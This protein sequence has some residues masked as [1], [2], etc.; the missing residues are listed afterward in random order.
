[1]NLQQ[2]QLHDAD[3]LGVHLDPVA[4]VAE[5]SLAYYPSEEATERVL[6]TLRFKD[7]SHFN[8]IV[9]LA[10]LKSHSG[11]GNV[12]YWVTGETPGVSYI[13][14]VRGLI[15]ITAT[16]VELVTGA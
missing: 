2:L 14:L 7:V 15:A 1:M 12:T 9:D 6:G 16:S 8:Q 13:Y 3:L 5:V 4:L 11:A 10:Q